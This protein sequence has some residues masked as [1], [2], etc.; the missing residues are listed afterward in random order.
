MADEFDPLDTVIRLVRS[1]TYDT[2]AHRVNKVKGLSTVSALGAMAYSR[3]RDDGAAGRRRLQVRTQAEKDAPPVESEAVRVDFHAADAELIIRTMIAAVAA[4]GVS[5]TNETQRILG[6]LHA[7]GA[8]PAEI[9]FARTHI[10]SPPT[11]EQLAAQVG[12]RET[13]VEVYAAALLA[14][15][16]SA[17]GSQTFLARLGKALDLTPDFIRDL[18][19]KWDD[20]PPVSS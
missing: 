13:A 19:A 10:H 4:E 2:D 7:T 14:T 1:T 5:E 20:P 17:T 18:H 12:S 6:Y 3:L 8:S 15:K 11:V 9:E 16:A